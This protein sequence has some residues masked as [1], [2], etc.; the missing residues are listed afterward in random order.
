MRD[1]LK[2]NWET[3]QFADDYIVKAIKK[4]VKIFVKVLAAAVKE[5]KEPYHNLEFLQ[6]FF[7]S[8]SDYYKF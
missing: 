7:D 8:A 2:T 6:L 4:L 5:I 3:A 1:I